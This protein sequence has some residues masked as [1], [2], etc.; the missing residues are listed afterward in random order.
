MDLLE[1]HI[2][3]R[4]GLIAGTRYPRLAGHM[5]E[6]MA[7]TLFR[8]SDLHLPAAAK[9][10]RMAIFCANTELCRITE[11]LVFT[12]PYR[13]SPLNRW[14]GPQLDRIATE[15]RSDTAL[16]IAA[17][18]SKMKFLSSAE[19]MIH[20]DLHSGSIMVTETDTRAIEPEFAFYGQI[21]RAHV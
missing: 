17:Q 19:A 12:D 15:F 3:L 18:H 9:K 11:D 10:E 16:K 6:F 20:G 13:D 2:I 14:T 8:T 4:K 1:P 7:E 5:A 21:G